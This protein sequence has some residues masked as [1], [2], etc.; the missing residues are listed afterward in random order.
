MWLLPLNSSAY[1]LFFFFPLS[2]VGVGRWYIC[3]GSVIHNGPTSWS[4]SLSVFSC[5]GATHLRESFFISTA[6]STSVHRVSDLWVEIEE[7][8]GRM[9]SGIVRSFHVSSCGQFVIPAWY[10]M[11]WRH[12][13]WW[14]HFFLAPFIL[15]GGIWLCLTL[16]CLYHVALVNLLDTQALILCVLYVLMATPPHQSL[17]TNFLTHL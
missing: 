11:T 4:L 7:I 9:L 14:L 8:R 5:F 15:S 16:L 17:F 12:I 10:L 2:V 1:S 13:Y 3:R 6:A